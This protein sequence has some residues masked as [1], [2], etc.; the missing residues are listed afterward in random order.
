MNIGDVTLCDLGKHD[1]AVEV[2]EE[3]LG[4]YR[5]LGVDNEKNANVYWII[6]LVKRETGDV[7]GALE[8]ARECVRIYDKLGITNTGSTRAGDMLMG[9]QGI[10]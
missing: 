2:Y 4:V 7:D 3:A 1:E 8:S 6:A 10:E 5:A 9:L